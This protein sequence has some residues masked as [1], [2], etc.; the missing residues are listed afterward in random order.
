MPARPGAGRQGPGRRAQGA[1][2]RGLR[3]RAAR[4]GA[5]RWAVPPASGSGS[6]S[7]GN[8]PSSSASSLTCSTAEGGAI[9]ANRTSWCAEPP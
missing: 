5:I 9:T 7:G 2:R 3:L 4:P 1:R 6:W 8:Q